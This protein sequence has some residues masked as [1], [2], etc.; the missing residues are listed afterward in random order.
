[1]TPDDMLA[2]TI[3]MTARLE[4]IAAECREITNKDDPRTEQ[5]I[6]DDEAWLD[7]IETVELSR[8]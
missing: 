6:A 1:M 4:R 8:P 5:E 2:E 3:I 7:Y